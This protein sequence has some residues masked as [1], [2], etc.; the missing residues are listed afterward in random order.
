LS[1]IKQQDL[2]LVNEGAESGLSPVTDLGTG[3]A[4]NKQEE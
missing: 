2:M 4:R 1:K 3:K